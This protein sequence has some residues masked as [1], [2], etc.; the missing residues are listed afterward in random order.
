[1][2]PNESPPPGRQPR[3][4]GSVVAVA[5]VVLILLVVAEVAGVGLRAWLGWWRGLP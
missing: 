1:M 4:I 2:S 3:T 5:L